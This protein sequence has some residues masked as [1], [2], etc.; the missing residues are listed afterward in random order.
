MQDA[1][2]LSQ[3]V[4]VAHIHH[5]FVT[6]S[7]EGPFD[8]YLKVLPYE[9]GHCQQFEHKWKVQSY[10]LLAKVHNNWLGLE[11]NNTKH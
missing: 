10:S 8:M 3:R 5:Q 1:S 9:K 7:F 2:T 6:P 4:F 11:K